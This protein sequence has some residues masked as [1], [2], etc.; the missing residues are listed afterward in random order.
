MHNS[1]LPQFRTFVYLILFTA[2]ILFPAVLLVPFHLILSAFRRVPILLDKFS[3]MTFSSHS[4]LLFPTS[5]SG[6][7]LHINDQKLYFKKLFLY[8]NFLCF[9]H[10]IITPVRGG[11]GFIHSCY[12]YTSS[13]LV[14]NKYCWMN[15]SLKEIDLGTK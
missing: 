4:L 14:L 6:Y 8:F 2:G 11:I 9:P 5:P 12:K 7:I 10:K 15:I 1:S 13:H 3:L